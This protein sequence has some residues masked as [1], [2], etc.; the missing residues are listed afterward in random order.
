MNIFALPMFALKEALANEQCKNFTCQICN[1]PVDV[2]KTGHYFDSEK[3]LVVHVA[4][5]RC[6]GQIDIQKSEVE[7]RR[8]YPFAEIAALRKAAYLV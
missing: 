5:F 3:L 6:H 8:Y 2:Y 1:K 7:K 4:E